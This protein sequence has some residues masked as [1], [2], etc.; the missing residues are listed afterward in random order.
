MPGMTGTTGTPEASSLPL[1][2]TEAH[3]EL[4]EAYAAHNYHPL[5]V[6]LSAGE[7]AW[8]TD[9]EGRRYLDCL[10]GYSALN[11]GHS[12]PRLVARAREQLG[13]LTLTSRAFYNDQLG[14]VRPRPR[15]ADRQGDD[16]ADELR[17][18]GRR[19]RDQGR[20]QVGLPGQGR[21]GEP[22]DDRRDGGQLPRPDH[23]HRV[24]LDRR[25]RHRPLRAVHPGLPARAVRRPRRP[26]GRHR[27]VHG[28]RAARAHP[29]RERRDHPAGGLPPAGAH[30][31]QL[32]PAS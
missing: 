18:R 27:R 12:H 26:R 2:D 11:F 3:I 25:R 1:S 29:G 16:P 20:P 23:D 21:P 13:R 4:N 31:V 9:V 5:R 8:V 24:V 19:D 7:G 22:G 15:A 30:A 10:A 28:R 17:R 32:R 14:P 6:V